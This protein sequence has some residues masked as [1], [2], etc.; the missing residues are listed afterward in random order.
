MLDNRIEKLAKNLIN[1]SIN[2][3]KNEKVLIE[4]SGV[5]TPLIEALIKE[6]YAVGG[7]P[8]V[9]IKD[10]K[11]NRA[12][13]MGTSEKHSKL[14]AKHTIPLMEDM[15][16]YIGI[17][18]GNNVF[19]FSGVPHENM[20]HYT[21]HYSKP[22]HRDIRVTKTKWVILR[23]PTEGMSQLANMSTTDFEDHYFN[24]CN[25]DYKKMDNAMD[26]LKKIMEKTDQVEIK[27]KNTHLTF[28]IKDIIAVKCSGHMNIPDGEIYT[29][30]VKNSVNGYIQYNV[31]STH[32][33]VR[34]DNIYFEFKDGKIMKATSSNTEELLK[35]L[36]TDEGA[37]YIGE[38]SFGLNP[39]INEPILDILFDEKING[40]IHFTPGA[41]YKDADNGN[42]SAVHWDLIQI[43]RP[44]YGG[45]EI[46]FDGV[47]IRKDGRFVL[48]QLL[49]LNPENLV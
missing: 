48:K 20:L 43:Q 19:E 12:L 18:G 7:F 33:G 31:P 29:A 6:A 14:W 37:R 5:D 16:A 2:L 40:S 42:V 17:A 49:P 47:L 27:A 13:L 34:H 44:E 32:S 30:P 41:S 36:D 35:V 28:S 21:M 38:F 23:Y 39:Y 24:V 26:A 10:P 8:L 11:V 15:D 45:G 25:L 9:N 3:Q 46:Y 4:A 1:Y 22:I